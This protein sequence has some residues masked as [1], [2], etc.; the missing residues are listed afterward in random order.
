MRIRPLKNND[1]ARAEGVIQPLA[2]PQLSAKNI[3]V[4]KTAL[5]KMSFKIFFFIEVHKCFK[6]LWK[7]N[8]DMVRTIKF[9]RETDTTRY[10]AF[11]HI[12]DVTSA[13]YLQYGVAV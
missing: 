10:P 11:Q 3:T 6:W 7:K 2:M 1:T 9:S 8:Y 5:K 4:K 13:M 12:C